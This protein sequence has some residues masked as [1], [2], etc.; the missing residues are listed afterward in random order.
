VLDFRYGNGA[1]AGTFVVPAGASASGSTPGWRTNSATVAKYLNAGAPGG[2]TAAKVVV[3][4]PGK[5]LKLTGKSAG[6]TPIDITAAGDPGPSGVTAVFTVNNGGE[7]VRHCTAFTAAAGSTI[8][9]KALA[10]GA[11][12]KLTLKAGV[13]TAC[14]P[15]PP[16]PLD[17]YVAYTL[18]AAG[19]PGPPSPSMTCSARPRRPSGSATSCSLPPTSTA[20]A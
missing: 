3:I 6:D 2:P 8:I 16:S 10:G 13:P 20:A 4:K 7:T 15:P 14:P 18:G 12:A 5:L 19:L 9:Q 11:G 17:H 1:T